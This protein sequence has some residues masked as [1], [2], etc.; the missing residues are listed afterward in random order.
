M[1]SPDHAEIVRATLPAV[2]AHGTEITAKF[3]DAMFAAHPELRHMFNQG[4]QANGEQRQALAMAVAAFAQRLTSADGPASVRLM[5]SRIANKHASLGVRPEQYAI[6]GRHL[7][8]AVADV[9]GAAV[10]PE[11]HAAWSEVYWLFATLLVA[12]EARLYQQASC[13]PAGPFRPWRVVA[14]RPETD[15]V[16]S[17]VLEPADGQGVPGY[18]PGQYVSV[19]VTLPDGLRQPRQYSLSRVPADDA[20]QITVRRVR[21]DGGTPDGAVSSFLHHDVA[22]GDLLEVSPPFGDLV[23]DDESDPLVLISAG[24]GVTPV[25]AMIDHLAATAP[26]RRVLALH[27]DRSPR[28]HALRDQIATAARAMPGLHRVTWYEQPDGTASAAGEEIRTGLMDI[29]G[30]SLPPKARVYMCGPI[31]FMRGVRRALLTAGIADERIHY[32]VFGPDLWNQAD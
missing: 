17:L 27:A 10:T 1:L 32:E 18:R 2:T 30:L 22:E 21:G 25:A 31:P 19:A 23:L 3:Y 14:R 5:L 24:I 29:T 4:N 7:M 26:D 13:S 15:D 6:V 28:T 8:E 16:F 9:L 11:V 12:E 20:I